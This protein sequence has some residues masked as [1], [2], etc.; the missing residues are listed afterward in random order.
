MIYTFNVFMPE[1]VK[2]SL[3]KTMFSGYIGQGP[4]V[5]EFEQEFTKKFGINK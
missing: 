1:S 3:I 2:E 5:D 4:K